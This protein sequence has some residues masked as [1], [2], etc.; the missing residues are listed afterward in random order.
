MS[1]V[2]NAPRR[3]PCIENIAVPESEDALEKRSRKA[4]WKAGLGTAL[5]SRSKEAR[6]PFGDF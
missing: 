6:F 2:E 3:E 5:R 4:K 1:R